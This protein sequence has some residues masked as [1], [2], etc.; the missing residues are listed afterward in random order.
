MTLP[1]QSDAPK[2]AAAAPPTSNVTESVLS[3]MLALI[4]ALAP[5]IPQVIDDGKAV[6]AGVEGAGGL[7]A[8]VDAAL[9]GALKIVGDVAGLANVL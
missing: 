2:A 4:L 7:I 1:A 5:L 6:V 3:K 8:K 9:D